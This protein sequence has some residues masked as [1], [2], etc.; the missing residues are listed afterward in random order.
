MDRALFLYRLS[1]SYLP[2]MADVH[3]R[4][5]ADP[6]ARIAHIG[7]GLGWFSI[8]MAHAYPNVWVDGFDVD[9]PI[10]EEAWSNACKVGLADRLTFHARDAADL[11][12]LNGSYDL[13][14]ALA[15]VHE[16]GNPV[17]V[18][19]TMRRLTGHKGTALVMIER[20]TSTVTGVLQGDAQAAGFHHVELLPLDHASFHLYRLHG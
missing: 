18:L 8:G 1:R 10:I 15:C 19:R 9:G 11:E 7:C 3:A 2:V 12:L 13:V 5:L 20:P 14:I 4:L 17:G 16:L 6:P